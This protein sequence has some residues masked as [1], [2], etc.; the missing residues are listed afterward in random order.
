MRHL[1]LWFLPTLLTLWISAAGRADESTDRVDRL[2]APWD[3]PGSPGCS[4]GVVRDG[5]LI[6]E[7][8][9]GLA[10]VE[11]DRRIGTE[12]EIFVA[13]VSKQFTAMAILLLEREG[14]LS[15]DDDVR[16]YLPELHDFGVPI[17]LRQMLLHTSGLREQFDLLPLAGWRMADV[18]TDDDV[19]RLACRQ[20]ELNFDPGSRFLYCN[21]GYTL[22]SRVVER[23]SGQP[24]GEFTRRRIF[25]PLGMGHSRF[26][27]E[28]DE[29]IP[30]RARSYHPAGTG[31]YK[32]AILSYGTVGATG[33]LTT[34]ADLVRWD[35]NFY[36]PRVGDAKL[37]D[38]LLEVGT[39]NDGRKLDY[40]LGL[41]VGEYRGLKYVEH[42]GS[43]AGFRSTILRFPAERFSVILLA[44]SSDFRPE[45]LAR[46]V[47][48]IYL[49]GKLGP[50][51]PEPAV[52]ERKEVAADPASFDAYVGEYRVVP[53]LIVT[54]AKE[55]GGLTAV[56][57]GE[58]KVVLAAA[59]ARE[60]FVP[61]EDLEITFDAPVDGRCP[62]VTIRIGRQCAPAG[63]I[64]RPSL[65][66]G[67]AEEL[68]GDFYSGELGV[69]YSVVRRDGRLMIS[70]PRGEGEL[71]PVS[72]DVFDAPDPLLQVT[73]DHAA[74]GRATGL[75]IDA[76]RAKHLRFSR[77]DLSR[78]NEA[79]GPR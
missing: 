23:V 3:K 60:F 10:D 22:A 46:R 75:R 48:D 67:Q 79:V 30:G 33:L 38:R 16:K 32:N 55:G 51:P 61:G 52:N 7:T 65:T 40:G 68:V 56:A 36:E 18:I 25:E 17:T 12:T 47:A 74:G 42:A 41:E 29:I 11:Q 57:L 53:G 37:I 45:E 1:G 13:S 71:R 43:E 49:D 76:I 78:P 77:V 59:S 54:V 70:Y 58:R 39:L 69:I 35:A 15:L 6:Y 64:V 63:R 44:N 20:R 14:K 26:P 9:V 24:L 21:T 5:K 50:A 62:S 73:F 19:F 4:L 28:Y 31:R 66:A 27:A 72:E 8:A 2:V 34:V